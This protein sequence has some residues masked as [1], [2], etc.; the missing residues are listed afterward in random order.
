MAL[1]RRQFYNTCNYL[2][3]KF[4][5]IHS[6]VRFNGDVPQEIQETLKSVPELETE[7]ILKEALKNPVLLESIK[8]RASIRWSEG[9]SDSLYSAVLCNIQPTGEKPERDEKGKIILK[10]QTDWEEELRK[11]K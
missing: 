6:R 4:E 10:E 9:L 1:T 11:Y 7:I 3:L 5:V 8:E 2:K